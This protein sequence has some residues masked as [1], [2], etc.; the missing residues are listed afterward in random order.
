MSVATRN[1]FAILDDDEA[2]SA[3][4][5]QKQEPTPAAAPATRGTAQKSRGG[6]AARGG[7]YY[8][9]GGKPPSKDAAPVTEEAEGQK[10][11]EGRDGR[12]GG[13]GRGDRGGRG[14]GRGG[15][16]GRGR[17]FDRHS[18]TGKTDS[19]KKIHQSWGGDDGNTEFKAEQAATAD[20]S[21]EATSNEWGADP[22][23]AAD[24]GG[25]PA[26]ATADAWATPAADAAAAPA[27][28]E[29]KPEGRPRRER[30][31][32]EE[33]NT[34]TLDQY[35]AQQKEKDT[36][37]PKLEGTRKANDGA[38]DIWKDAVA[39]AKNEEE[40]AYFVGKGKSAPK[41]RTKKEEK[42]YLEIDARFERPDRGGRGRGGRGGDR[43]GDRGDRGRG[44]RARGGGARGGRPNNGA[45]VVNV[46][47]QS[48]FPSL[49]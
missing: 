42:V 24:W 20:A 22:A 6:P 1:P 38:D 9:R 19:D 13:R 16:R 41:A 3:P 35:L 15:P 26:E 7:K 32:E 49:S 2:P 21:A 45:T 31:P 10:K 4:A 40:E 30:E 17:P 27:E 23:A 28:G 11:F 36:A 43:G 33:D 48:A 34:L 14:G 37:V 8:A 29:A 18:Q 39:I 44:G 12:E 5:V 46:D 25:A 47:D